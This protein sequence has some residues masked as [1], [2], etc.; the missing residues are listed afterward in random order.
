MPDD[1]RI[2]EARGI[3]KRLQAL[4]HD[5]EQA[6][7]APAPEPPKTPEPQQPPKERPGPGNTGVPK[8]TKLR[9]ETSITVIDTGRVIEDLDI[10]GRVLIRA[11]NVTIRRCRIR[12]SD[13]QVA[14]VY[15]IS[16]PDSS[17]TGLVLEDCEI[18]GNGR[19][20]LCVGTKNYTL[21]RCNVHGA[22]GDL[23]RADG[24]VIV[25][26]SWLH[27]IVRVDGGHHDAVQT[28]KGRGVTLRGNTIDIAQRKTDGSIDYMNACYIISAQAEVTD[29]AI[30][31]N[32]LNGGNYALYLGAGGNGPVSGVTAS[33][34]TFGPDVR[35]NRAITAKGTATIT[36]NTDAKGQAI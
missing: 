32:Y 34:N 4:T 13:T 11:S 26:D 27:D 30:I 3:L 5:L 10:T 25:Q 35:P 14:S 16:V 29:V 6:L 22:A 8:G 24:N 18:D 15:P 12:A 21:I 19:T 7:D 33:G 36:G 1:P 23:L 17:Y 31:D 20:S 9:A 28:L 2:A